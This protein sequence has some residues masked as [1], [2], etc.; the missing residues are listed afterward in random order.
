MATIV[1][2]VIAEDQSRYADWQ[3]PSQEEWERRERCRLVDRWGPAPD[4]EEWVVQRPL[5]A[6][7]MLVEKVLVSQDGGPFVE[8]NLPVKAKLW[9]D[10]VEDVDFQRAKAESKA[11]APA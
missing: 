5:P 9:F 1:Q 11:G 7:P 6:R 10:V 8:V 3:P 2:W 4:D